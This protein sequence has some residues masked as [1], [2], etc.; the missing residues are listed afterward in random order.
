MALRTSPSWRAS[1]Q[2]IAVLPTTN[3]QVVYGSKHTQWQYR[4]VKTCAKVLSPLSEGYSV[5]G[6]CIFGHVLKL[7][8]KLAKKWGKELHS[9]M[10]QMVSPRRLDK[11]FPGLGNSQEYLHLL[12]N[13]G[14]LWLSAC[15]HQI[16]T[17]LPL[18]RM[19]H[20]AVSFGYGISFICFFYYILH[21]PSH[22]A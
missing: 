11:K 19:F 22:H 21:C 18:I 6:C 14:R 2:Y 7:L 20:S 10:C 13:I 3:N 1:L 15:F 4:W 8:P 17:N 9:G 16:I 12:W 5:W